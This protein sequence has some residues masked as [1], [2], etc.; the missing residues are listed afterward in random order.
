[1]KWPFIKKKQ[2]LPAVPSQREENDREK[3][4]L[5]DSHHY[6]T[7]NDYTVNHKLMDLYGE[8]DACIDRIFES[9]EL[10]E[11]NDDYFDSTIEMAAAIALKDLNNQY[12]TRQ[13]VICKLVS[14]RESDISGL[15]SEITRLTTRIEDAR[16]E[17][18]HY[19]RLY[20]RLCLRK[21]EK[22]DE[23]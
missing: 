20:N 11:G 7:I 4:L 8:I 18:D 5:E 17:L 14:W 22:S 12:A 19:T 23:E 6:W 9:G 16:R 3:L 10:D 1:M 13:E 2:E 21:K 15:Q